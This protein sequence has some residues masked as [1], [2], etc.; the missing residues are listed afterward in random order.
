MMPVPENDDFDRHANHYTEELNRC[1][2]CSGFSSSDFA[3]R[4]V[5][6]IHDVLRAVGSADEPIRILNFG[7][8]IG[9]SEPYLARSFGQ[10]EIF[11][12]DI[13][14]ESVERA[15]QSTRGIARIHVSVFDGIRLPYAG[16]FDAIL[17]AG[18]LHHIAPNL[19]PDIL[20]ELHGHLAIGGHLFIFEHNPW[21]P[22]TRR[23]VQACSFDTN[24][25]LLSSRQARTLLQSAGFDRPEIRYIVFFPKPCASLVRFERFLRWVPA[26][27]QYFCIAQKS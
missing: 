1:V 14:R 8:G 17:V 3:E 6:E 4:K 22:V 24:A 23:I 12:V 11:S 26:G 13:S 27:A 7:C 16:P 25:S 18:V 10:A 20:H 21:N 19:R 9:V 15:K 5:R 2:E